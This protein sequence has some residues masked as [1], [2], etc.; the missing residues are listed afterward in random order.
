MLRY[1]TG[2][3]W[4]DRVTSRAVAERCRLS[5]LAHILRRGRLRW[6]GHVKRLDDHRIL[7]RG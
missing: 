3:R 1:M 5:E 4:E 7:K 6:F 2:V